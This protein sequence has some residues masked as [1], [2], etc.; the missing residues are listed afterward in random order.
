MIIANRIGF[1]MVIIGGYEHRR[2]AFGVIRGE[3]NSV[4]APERGNIHVR[5]AD[6]A[7]LAIDHERPPEFPEVQTIVEAGHRS[8]DPAT[9]YWFMAPPGV[10]GSST[11]LGNRPG[12][13]PQD[14]EFLKW[15]DRGLV[16]KIVSG[17]DTLKNVLKGFG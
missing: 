11:G 1:P 7:L 5:T 3:L 9:D 6:Q 16:P 15:A 13:D 14:P 2:L 17:E 4:R 10:E 8:R 12:K